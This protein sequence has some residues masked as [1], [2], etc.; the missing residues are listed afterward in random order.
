MSLTG[1]KGKGPVSGEEQDRV[2]RAVLQCLNRYP[3]K[4]VD[5]IG[6]ESLDPDEPGMALSVIQG[7]YKVEEY[8]NGSYLSEYQ[9]KIIYRLQ[10][11]GTDGRLKADESLNRMAD[12]LTQQTETIDLGQ[13]KTVK[14]LVCNSRSSLFGRY[15]DMSEDHQ[16]LMS[17]T[18]EVQ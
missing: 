6:F 18:Y 14:D 10:P 15:Q 11:D 9:F 17:M 7:A 3:Q 1:N 8:I 12:W 2:S 4:P 13:G 16:I 5:K